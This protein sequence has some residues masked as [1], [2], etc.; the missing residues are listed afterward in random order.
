MKDKSEVEPAGATLSFTRLFGSLQI[1]PFCEGREA[2][3]L[4]PRQKA[5]IHLF[6]HEILAAYYRLIT[7]VPA[8]KVAAVL[9]RRFRSAAKHKIPKPRH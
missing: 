7:V 1:S 9:N 2:Q 3:D 8:A 6:L 4:D 5:A